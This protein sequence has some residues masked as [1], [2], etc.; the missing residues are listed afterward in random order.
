MEGIDADAASTMWGLE[1]FNYR[2]Q[3]VELQHSSTVLLAHDTRGTELV[4]DVIVD[5]MTGVE[6]VQVGSG[7]ADSA[8]LTIYDVGSSQE[9]VKGLLHRRIIGGTEEQGI[10]LEGTR[11]W[12]IGEMLEDEERR[13]RIAISI[14]GFGGN[15]IHS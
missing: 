15:G 4:H 12:R 13:G 11:R 10:V 3:G 7:L 8:V 5:T 2:L 6:S 9:I 14:P 1:V